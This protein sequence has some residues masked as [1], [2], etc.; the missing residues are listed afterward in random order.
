MANGFFQ[1]GEL[2]TGGPNT[3]AAYMEGLDTGSKIQQR[4][5]STISAMAQARQRVNKAKAQEELGDALVAMGAPSQYATILNSGGNPD[6]V[7]KALLGEQQMGFRDTIADTNVPFEQRQASAQAI[8]GKVV[9]PFQF[10]PGG[11]LAT[12][13]FKPDLQVTETGVAQIGAD[14]ALTGQR[15]SLAA[16]YEDKRLHPDKYK[17]STTI[18]LGG[19]TLGDDIL[20][21]V[22]ESTMP[23]DFRPEAATGVVG[24]AKS[25]INTL[26]DMVNAGIPYPDTDT[27]S[28]AMQDLHTRTQIVGQQSV[29][30]RPSNYLMQTLAS[31]GVTPNNPFKSDERSFNRMVQTSNFFGGEID[32]LRRILNTSGTAMTKSDRIQYEDALRNLAALKQDYDVTISRFG[33]EDAPEQSADGWSTTPSGVRYRVKPQ[34][35]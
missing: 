22:G 19:G 23:A 24:A 11:E 4:K 27:A 13:V 17:T 29:P 31:F 10:G 28:N 33:A 34:G 16:L 25:G 14:T 35:Q 12:D 6:Q 2:L 30:G 15:N 9:N 1:L 5:A 7:M 8:E 20:A 32:R 21:D 3:D 18:N 26:F